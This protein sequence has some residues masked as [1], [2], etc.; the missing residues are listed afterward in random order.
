MG[1]TSVAGTQYLLYLLL[2]DD[3]STSLFNLK[4]KEEI[5]ELGRAFSGTV[6]VFQDLV[7]IVN[8]MHFWDKERPLTERRFS[9]DDQKVTMKLPNYGGRRIEVYNLRERKRV[10]E[11]T[12]PASGQLSAEE[13]RV[14]ESSAPIR[15]DGRGHHYVEVIPDRSEWKLLRTNFGDMYVSPRRILEYDSVGR[16]VG[17]RCQ[18]YCPHFMGPEGPKS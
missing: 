16:F 1:L 18:V 11:D 12:L 5:I 7:Y 6:Q 10:R 15:M 3:G 17:V 14:G 2:H 9:V 13:K 8:P 4:T